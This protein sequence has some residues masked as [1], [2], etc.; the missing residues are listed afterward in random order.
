M[1]PLTEQFGWFWKDLIPISISL[2]SFCYVLFVEVLSMLFDDEDCELKFL[3]EFDC[4]AAFHGM[5]LFDGRYCPFLG[6]IDCVD[7]G[8]LDVV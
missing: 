6:P 5:F 1:L 2:T 8:G 4:S 3:E 7:W